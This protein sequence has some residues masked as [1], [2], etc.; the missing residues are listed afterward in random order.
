MI[1]TA[2]PSSATR[3]DPA[4]IMQILTAEHS[5]LTAMRSQVPAIPPVLLLGAIAFGIVLALQG[6]YG[7]RVFGRAIQT[8]RDREVE[9]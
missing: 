9:A 4:R 3:P 5:S 2:H 8:R 6:F 7:S 1:L